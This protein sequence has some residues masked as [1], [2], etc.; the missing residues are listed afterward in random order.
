MSS[1]KCPSCGSDSI[2]YDSARGEYTCSCGRVL[3][4]N[5]VVSEVTFIIFPPLT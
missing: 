1:S 3:Q 4:E 2:V 5:A